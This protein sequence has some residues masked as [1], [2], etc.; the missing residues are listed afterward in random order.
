MLFVKTSDIALPMMFCA[1]SEE[2][3]FVYLFLARKIALCELIGK[4]ATKP[5]INIVKPKQHL[6]EFTCNMTF[7]ANGVLK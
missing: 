6:A 1:V 2:T 5:L 4:K 3:P 7:L